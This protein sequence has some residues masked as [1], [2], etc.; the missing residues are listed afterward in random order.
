MTEKLG[1]V[2]TFYSYKGGVGRSMA[3]ANVAALLAKWGKKVLVVDWDL[4]APG[5]HQ[6]F[7]K[8][9]INSSASVQNK[10]GVLDMLLSIDKE[11]E[12]DWKKEI[13]TYELGGDTTLDLLS[14]GQQDEEY[15]SKLRSLNWAEIIDLGNVYDFLNTLREEWIHTYDYVLID[16]RTGITDIGDICT[17]LFPDVLVM[18]FASNYQN[19]EGIKT[20]IS[21]VVPAHSNLPVDRNKLAILPIPSRTEPYTEYDL[22]KKWQRIFESEFKEQYYDWIPKN[23]EPNDILNKI[24]IPYISKWS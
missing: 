21:R 12:V 1:S 15:T 20:M 4:E 24:F 16:S 5:L 7:N 19:I 6:Y 14:A 13:I 11:D 8:K 17:V 10:K 3:L 2:Y 9:Y 22:N 18:I 23:M